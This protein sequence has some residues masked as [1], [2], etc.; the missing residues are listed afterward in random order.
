MTPYGLIESN[1]SIDFKLSNPGSVYFFLLEGSRFIP[2]EIQSL[3]SK[4]YF[5]NLRE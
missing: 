5:E 2:L 4:A 1:V 3:V